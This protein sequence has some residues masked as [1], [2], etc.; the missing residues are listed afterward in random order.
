MAV[1]VDIEGI[2]G[3]GKGTQAE[4][5]RQLLV[6]D[7]IAAEVIS[8]PRYRETRF[9]AVIGEYLNGKFGGLE[10][11]HPLLVSL[12]FAGDRFESR[13]R[14]QTAI[15][16]NRVVI[17]DRY[18]PSNIAHQA[19]KLTGDDRLRLVEWIEDLEFGIYGLPR[20]DLK[21]FLRLP[22]AASLQL[23]ARKSR[24]SYTD[25]AAD[26][27]E[28][29]DDYLR[30]VAGLYDWLTVH[31]PGWRIVECMQ[32]PGR[33][34]ETL[35]EHADMGRSGGERIVNSADAVLAGL[36]NPDDIAAE[37]LAIVRE[38]LAAQTSK[39]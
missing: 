19:A 20:P 27:Q 33:L 38:S 8:F 16:A 15:A 39:A 28:A 7:G 25:R 26:I 9:G 35:P 24:R 18:V 29:A 32:S 17:L 22:V 3:S 37:L 21:V 12:L 5:L 34:D 2:D 36:R 13:G 14:L 6:A 31:Q 11:V 23:I 30:Q 10:E 1:L 4:L